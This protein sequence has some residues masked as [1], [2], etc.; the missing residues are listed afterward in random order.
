MDDEELV[1]AIFQRDL[2]IK[3]YKH[4]IKI[5]NYIIS[6]LIKDSR[7]DLLK[8]TDYRERAETEVK[9]CKK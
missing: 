6:Y 4:E 7:I 5:L 8:L 1:E 3:T 9:L 2:K